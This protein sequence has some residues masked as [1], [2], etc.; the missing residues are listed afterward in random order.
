[1]LEATRQM[2]VATRPVLDIAGRKADFTGTDPGAA[3]FLRHE[4]SRLE[5]ALSGDVRSFVRDYLDGFDRL[6]GLPEGG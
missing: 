4:V 2:S 5:R 3:G 6:L 1:M